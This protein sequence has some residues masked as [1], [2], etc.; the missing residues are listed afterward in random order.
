[1]AEPYWT[2]D[3]SRDGFP[4]QDWQEGDM[5]ERT[6]ESALLLM[7]C[8]SFAGLLVRR[9]MKDGCSSMAEGKAR[10]GS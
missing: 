7:L 10:G 5:F 3:V 8:S 4:S 6:A 2:D 9:V 1:V